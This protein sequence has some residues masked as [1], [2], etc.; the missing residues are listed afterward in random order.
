MVLV[1]KIEHQQKSV[2]A[3][4]EKECTYLIIHQDGEKFLQIDTYSSE[5]KKLVGDE[6]QTIRFG[7]EGIARLK[8]ILARL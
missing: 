2:A 3:H 6:S 7:K 4:K 5:E 8:E 1:R